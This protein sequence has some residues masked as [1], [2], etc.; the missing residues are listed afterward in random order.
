[1]EKFKEKDCYEGRHF[2]YE[3]EPAEKA[4]FLDVQEEFS[5]K[6]KTSYKAS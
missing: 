5:G 2:I 3:P 4:G 6:T 1:M